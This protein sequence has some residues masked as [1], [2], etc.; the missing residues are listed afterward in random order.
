MSK[1]VTPTTDA[2]IL[3]PQ[4]RLTVAEN[5]KAVD[6]NERAARYIL[7]LLGEAGLIST[8]V[9]QTVEVIRELSSEDLSVGFT[10]WATRMTYGFLKQAGTDYAEGLAAKLAAGTNPGVTGMAGSFKE[11]AGA[12][13]IDLRAEPAANGDGYVINGKLGW[14]SNLYEDAV[15]VTGAKTAAGHKFIFAFEAGHDGVQFGAPFGLLGLNATQSAWV[16]FDNVRIPQSQVLAEDFQSFMVAVR[17]VFVL[18][19]IAECLGVAEAA[20]AQAE[21]HLTGVKA[22]FAEDL[23]AAQAFNADVLSRWNTLVDEVAAGA[24]PNIVELLELRLDA[25]QAAVT[26]ANIEVRVAGGAGYARSSS[27]SRRY[28]EA[29]FIPVQSP[30]EAQLRF[31]LQQAKA[32]ATA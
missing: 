11:L 29:S 20:A 25:S 6:K 16:S 17:P 7:P 14:A 12:G 9:R 26:S 5:A 31:Q 3:D 2:I 15:M 19:Q 22:T 4:L 1:N 23:A 28:R 10:T 27:A 30:S 24:E 8:D 21:P 18:S 13:E 32:Q